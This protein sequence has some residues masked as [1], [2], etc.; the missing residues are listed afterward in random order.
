MPEEI[1]LLLLKIL[2]GNGNLEPITDLG[3]EYSQIINF[4]DLLIAEQLITASENKL[5]VSD[6]GIKKI[7]K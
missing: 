4:I 2:K 3:Y 1:K 6:L 7:E 5:E